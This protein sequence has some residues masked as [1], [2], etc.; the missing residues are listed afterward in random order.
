MGNRQ[1]KGSDFWAVLAR[2]I[3]RNRTLIL[4][5]ILGATLL[6][7]QKFVEKFGDEGNLITIALN[8][9][10]LFTP[11]RLKA[12]KKL[13]Q[14]INAFPEVGLVLSIDN[15][16]A[17]KKDSEAQQLKL[18]AVQIPENP[19]QTSKN[20]KPG[21]FKNSLFITTFYSIR[22]PKQFDP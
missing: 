19:T 2:A 14:Q 5:G 6:W 16:Q 17:L 8:D 12:W 13:N 11:D 10:K 9:P 21:F 7:Y 4:L 1:R 18:E 15:V 3:L 20:L 22:K